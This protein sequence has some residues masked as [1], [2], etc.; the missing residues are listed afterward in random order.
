VSRIG[1]P[2][3][4]SRYCT[5]SEVAVIGDRDRGVL[6]S[7]VPLGSKRTRMAGSGELQR[8]LKDWYLHSPPLCYGHIHQRSHF[9]IPYDTRFPY[10]PAPILPT[11]TGDPPNDPS[12]PRL[13]PTYDC[14][15]RT[16]HR[17]KQVRP[18]GA[19]GA[20]GLAT[21]VAPETPAKH[22]W[23]LLAP[24]KNH[25]CNGPMRSAS[26]PFGQLPSATLTLR[27]TFQRSRAT[28]SSGR[29]EV[30]RILSSKDWKP[31]RRIG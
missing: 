13:T 22:Q 30:R 21:Q 3:R 12:W 18:P 27:Q 8:G 10:S 4:T 28:L 20:G 14:G 23:R 6:G 24:S 31:H 15:S 1:E 25:R 26:Q 11:F 2:G 7:W 17:R 29:S 5:A 9:S 16:T 19:T